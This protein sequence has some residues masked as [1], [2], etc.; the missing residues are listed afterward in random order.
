MPLIKPFTALIPAA[1][2]QPAIVTR[3]LEY[4]STGEARL[5][6][7]ENTYSFLHLINP[8]LKHAYLRDAHQHLVFRKIKD[9]FDSFVAQKVLVSVARPCYY[10]Y[11][12]SGNGVSQT[13]LWTLSEVS[14]YL[15]GS[16]K[17]HEL[18][19]KRREKLLSDYLEHT[20]LDANPVLITYA[21][22][23]V[24]EA[25]T[26]RYI[27][28]LPV[29]DFTFADQTVHK[30]WLIDEQKDIDQITAEFAAMPSVY[31]ADG[32]HRAA[33]M[34]NMELFSTVYM[35]TDEIQILQFNRL[36]RDLNGLQPEEFLALIEKSFTVKTSGEA[37]NPVKLHE[38]GMYLKGQWYVLKP[39][40]DLYDEQDPVE[41]LDVNILQELLLAPLLGIDDPR[42]AAR[43]TFEG[44]KTPVT[45]LAQMIDNGLYE[46]AFTL[47]TVSVEQLIKVADA[48][49]VMP[50]K[51]TWIEPKFLVGILTNYCTG[52]G[53]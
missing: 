17:R 3:P 40:A 10:I 37:V 52:P 4:Y 7:S 21:A 36:V 35:N 43:I 53:Q 23:E 18:T 16:I 12:V 28:E 24:I 11:Q 49:K 14:S 26:A 20:G 29:I 27:K 22:N 25:V 47:F 8:A 1:H 19:V 44:G 51:S 34:A 46:V 9:D 45:A 38:I 5:I 6:V 33:A 42:T 39:H 13:G 30:V 31:I 32:H 2:L 50:P 48:G 41:V 15:D